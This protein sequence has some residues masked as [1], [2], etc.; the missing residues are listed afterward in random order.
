[1]SKL[2]AIFSLVWVSALVFSSNA[3]A[4]QSEINGTIRCTGDGS[5]DRFDA[6]LKVKSLPAAQVQANENVQVEVVSMSLA[7]DDATVVIPVG[8]VTNGYYFDNGGAEPSLSLRALIDF[9]DEASSQSKSA[10]LRL[11]SATP[12]S[13]VDTHSFVDMDLTSFDSICRFEF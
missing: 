1:M 6:V 9:K 3:P 8:T 2:F 12:D 4:D 7:G 11:M 13:G 10:S 5:T